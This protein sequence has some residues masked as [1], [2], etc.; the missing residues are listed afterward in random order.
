MSKKP[1]E[2]KLANKYLGRGEYSR[3]IRLLEPKIPLFLENKE[4]YTTLAKAFFY[5]GDTAGSK[6]YF[7]RG[8]KISWDIDSALYLGVLGL[9]RRD[10]NSSIRIWLDILDEDPENKIAKNGLDALKK[11]STLEDLETFIH[12]KK[13]DKL[14]PRKPIKFAISTKISIGIVLLLIAA[15]IYFI[16][17]DLL[18]KIVT[19]FEKPY[20]ENVSREGGDD[21][22]LIDLNKDYLDFDNVSKYSFTGA[23]I[24]EFFETA[25]ILFLENSDNMVRSY[26]NLIKYSNAN[27]KIKSKARRLESYLIDPNWANYHDEISFKDVD[28]NLFQYENCL[29]RWKGSISNLNISNKINFDLLVGYDDR[30]TLEGVVPVILNQNIKIDD[31]QPIEVFG[32]IKLIEGGFYIEAL[33]VMHYI[34]RN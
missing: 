5:T 8:Q 24:E 9:K 21:F 17:S 18:E 23:Q 26:L 20:Q 29:V 11:Y 6:L 4:F 16:K 31:S 27:E 14:V 2:I 3:V 25:H 15:S 1:K 22:S 12:S 10:F 34:N 30:K 33:T 28:N 32:K 7:D 13:I 19:A